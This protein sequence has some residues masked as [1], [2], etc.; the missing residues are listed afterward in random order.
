MYVPR[1]FA[2]DS[3]QA[4]ELLRQVVV[5]QL[6]TATDSGLVA[7]LLPWVV[8]LD[9]NALL[10]HVARPNP[11]WQTPWRGEAVVLSHGPNGYVSPSGYAS[12]AEH[13]RVVPTWNYAAVQ[14]HGELVVHDDVD[15]VADVVRRLTER[16]EQHRDEPWAVT[17]AP[18]DYLA[19]QYRAIVGVELRITRLEASMKMSQ[20]KSDA[21]AAGVAD[22]F[23]A[24]G[25]PVIAD[26]I[27]A[28][29]RA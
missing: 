20:N 23:A 8:D 11:Q 24:S 1:P 3:E 16:H 4:R 7:T 6:V 28:S 26:L 27:R 13:G 12:K 25:S 17:D 29:R 14:V 21:D 5:G 22:G 18:S 10:G 15:W 9:A 19:G 2:V